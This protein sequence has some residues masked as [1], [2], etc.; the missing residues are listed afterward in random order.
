M[1]RRRLRRHRMAKTQRQL[2]VVKA[3]ACRLVI[4]TYSSSRLT[5]Q[6]PVSFTCLL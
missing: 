3:Q 4:M 2:P 5:V 1:A 6:G